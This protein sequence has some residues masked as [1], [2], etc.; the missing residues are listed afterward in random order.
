MSS[1]MP[2]YARIDLAFE[3]GEGPYLIAADGRRYLDFATGIAVNTLGHSHPHLVEALTDQAAKLW[4]C[5][6]LYNIPGQDRLA[7]R[8]CDHSF[9]DKVFFCNSGAEAM[10]GVIKVARRY[11]YNKGEPERFRV[12]AFDGAFHGRTLATIAAGGNQKALEGFGPAVDGFDHVAFGNTNEVRAAITG[13]TAAI[14]V[15]PIQGEGGIRPAD[16][17]FLKDLRAI[18]DEFGLLLL[19]DEVQ[20]GIGHTGKLF[21]YEWHGVEPDV[22]GLAKGLGSGFPVGAVLASD[23]AA[24]GMVPGTHGSTFGGNPLAVAAGN[25]VLDVLLE[26]GFLDHVC[27]IGARLHKDVAAVV[28]RHPDVLDSVRGQGLMVGIKC[29]VT[30]MDLVA[31]MRERDVLMVPAGENVARMLPPLNIDENHVE[32]AV[33]ALDAA[34]DAL[35]S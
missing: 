2:T 19:F 20:T 7:E 13:E 25:A 8:L 18:A 32:E 5:S 14:L 34:C 10:E 22:M 17:R 15:E 21:A 6:N 11:H 3:R 27:D 31:A 4:H 1:V 30:N 28:E 24:E 16:T 9:A 26:D 12:I 35:G 29:K 33:A 23:A